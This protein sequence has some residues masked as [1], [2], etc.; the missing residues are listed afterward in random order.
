M[1]KI[2]KSYRQ[3][4]ALIDLA[5][6]LSDEAPEGTPKFGFVLTNRSFL[7]PL[8]A[9][10]ISGLLAVDAPFLSPV[11]EYLQ[12]TSPE[13]ITENII[14]II[15][16]ISIIWSMI[17]KASTSAKAILTR[18]Q[19]EKAVVEV[20]GDDQLAKALREATIMTTK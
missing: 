6:R 16:S 5:N 14:A 13:F 8:I 18:K 2:F 15:I 7:V 20:V 17:E 9:L 19:A 12:S 4:K 1:L 11:K 10:I 3:I